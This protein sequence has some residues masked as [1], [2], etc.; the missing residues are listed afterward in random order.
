M[1]IS[2]RKIQKL[3]AEAFK[4]DTDG[5]R[6]VDPDRVQALARRK[7]IDSVTAAYRL[8]RLDGMNHMTEYCLKALRGIDSSERI[9]LAVNAMRDLTTD[10]L[11]GALAKFAGGYHGSD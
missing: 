9:Q 2:F 5:K 4:A 7:N 6:I 11:M 3:F 1:N 10:E 8:G